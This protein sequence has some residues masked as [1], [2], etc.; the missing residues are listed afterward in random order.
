MLCVSFCKFRF[1]VDPRFFKNLIRVLLCAVLLNSASI[2]RAAGQSLNESDV[3][4]YVLLDQK[5]NATEMFYRLSQKD[6]KWVAEGKSPGGKWSNI[7]CDQGCEYRDS[8]SSEIETYFPSD[9]RANVDIACIQNIAVAFCRYALKDDQRQRGYVMIALVTGR[10]VPMFVRRVATKTSPEQLLAVAQ[11]SF[12]WR[13]QKNVVYPQGTPETAVERFTIKYSSN[14]SVEDVIPD[15]NRYGNLNTA[16]K[17]AAFVASPIELPK[18][19]VGR[20]GSFHLL[21]SQNK[22]ER[23]FFNELTNKVRLYMISR[24]GSSDDRSA[25]A[26]VKIAADGSLVSCH[27][28]ETSGSADFDKDLLLA[29]KEG[30]PYKPP[31]GYV[32]PPVFKV[33]YRSK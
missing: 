24:Y 16:V 30:A 32:P 9:W 26:M 6:G 3:G 1:L 10:S 29:I 7:S 12:A 22:P 17:N 18:E 13:L 5:R 20:S 28:E 19:F 25:Q 2:G 8:N 14:G 21:F 15:T 33:T 4:T 27:V 31:V 11:A 23:I